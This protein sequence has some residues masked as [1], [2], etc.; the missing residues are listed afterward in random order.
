MW[1]TLKLWNEESNR[2]ETTALKEFIIIAII[3]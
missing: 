1:H 3:A 2:V